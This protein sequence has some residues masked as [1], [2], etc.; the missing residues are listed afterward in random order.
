MPDER[1]PKEIPFVDIN[2]E[3]FHFFGDPVSDAYALR[4]VVDSFNQSST[5]R[6]ANHDQRWLKAD[7]LTVAKFLCG[8]GKGLVPLEQ[9]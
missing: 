2:K 9:I 4:L 8:C 7:Q 5:W 1:D 3:P 6:Q